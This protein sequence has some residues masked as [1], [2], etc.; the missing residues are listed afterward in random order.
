P[1][2][3]LGRIRYV[4]LNGDQ[5]VDDND[6]T[7]LGSDQPKFTGGLNVGLSYK[8]FDMSFF[9][10]GMVRDAWNNARFY[11]DFFQL[12]TGNHG[13]RLL[14]AWDED[15][16]FNSNIPALTAVNLND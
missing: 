7:W 6:R 8:S 5:V 3:D 1:G 15:A 2:K 16:N 12:W 9:V 10:T 11:T 13:D 4:D 14:K